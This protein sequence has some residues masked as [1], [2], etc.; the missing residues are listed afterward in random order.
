MRNGKRWLYLAHRWSGIVLCLFMAMWFFSGVVMIYVGYP[1]LT[2]QERLAHLPPLALGADCCIG[3]RQALE[4]A[5]ATQPE[6]RNEALPAAGGGRTRG[7]R[8]DGPPPDIRLAM[9]GDAPY[10]LVGESG[11][12]PT[13]VDARSGKVATGF[14]T[15]HALAVAQ[16]FAPDARPRL[17]ETMNQDIFTVSR[18]LDPHRPLHRIALDDAA[19]TE[20]YV[21]SRTGEVIRE[22]TRT[23]RG[24]NYVGSILHWL[25]PLKGELLDRWRPD[26]IITLSLFGTVLTAL[27]IWVGL[28]RWRF[29]GRFANRSHSP[30]RERWM[31]WHHVG[32]LLFGLVTFTWIISGLFSMN[33]WRIFESHGPRPDARAMAGTT[34]EQAAIPL[35]PQQA[36]AKAHFDVRELGVQLFAGR[37][38]FVLRAGT[39][40]TEVIA[41]DRNDG[42][43]FARF[44]DDA[45]AAAALRLIPEHNIARIERLDHYDNYYYA[46]R[47]HTMT[48]HVERRLPMLRVV[49][50]DPDHTWVHLDPYTGSVLGK[51]DDTGRLRRWLFNFLHSFDVQGFIDQRPLWDLVLVLASCGGFVICISGTV[52]GWRR[53]RRQ[54]P[55]RRIAATTRAEPVRPA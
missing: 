18:A 11:R 3:P 12:S 29:G 20:L 25:Y 53:L 19:G 6:V 46:R 9:V 37:A 14:G 54:Q 10:W 23:E 17:I 8:G 5:R 4:A 34:V 55:R 13:A 2:A 1:K 43:P 47:P 41:A 31:R 48:G 39:G 51:T 30:Y 7:T 16:V 40:A 26:V 50:D 36:I 27:G 42:T 35:T 22:S 24:W 49:Y 21:S 28:L 52:M 15:G 38:Y 44:P 45:L 33:P 32:G